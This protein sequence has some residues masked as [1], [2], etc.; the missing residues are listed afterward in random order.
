MPHPSL[1]KG[2]I[3][4]LLS[5]LSLFAS[6]QTVS[7][8]PGRGF[9]SDSISVTLSTDLPGGQIYFTTDGSKPTDTSNLYVDPLDIY[10]T[11]PLR[12]IAISASSSTARVTHT[13]IYLDSVINQPDSIAGWPLNTYDLGK[14]SNTAVQDYEMDSSIV[15]DPAYTADLLTGL[16]AIPTMSIVMDKDEF[17]DMNDG[18]DKKPTSVEIIYPSE[19]SKNEQFECGIES[20]SHLRTKRSYKLNDL[21]GPI[22]TN[23]FKNG[24]W[25]NESAADEFSDTKIVLRAGNNDA[26]SRNWLQNS[27]YT[28]DMWYRQSQLDMHGYGGRGVFVHL[29]VNGIYWGLFNPTERPDGGFKDA[30]FGGDFADWLSFEHDG[31]RSGDDT[32]HNYLKGDLIDKDMSDSAN[33]EELKE[34]LDVAQFSDYMILSW[35]PGMGDWPDN[36][37]YG[38]NLNNPPE[39][40]FFLCWDGE[41]TWTSQNNSS[42]GA[43]VSPTFRSS[44]AGGPYIADIWQAARQN[45]DFMQLFADRVYKHCFNDGVMTDSASRARWQRINDHIE[46]AIIAESARW[47]DLVGTTRTK[48]THWTPEVSRIDGLMQGNVARFL[49]ALRAE[50]YYPNLDAPTFNGKSGSVLPGFVLKLIN[51]NATGNI[52]YTLDGS[53]PRLP[54]GGISASAM[55]YADSLI[56][57]TDHH[58]IARVYDGTE[59]SAR[60]LGDFN[61]IRIFINEFLAGND[62]NL[63]DPADTSYDDWIEI[64][65]AGSSPV[66]VG[67]MFITDDL[68]DPGQYQIPTGFPQSTTIA[69]NGFLL[70]WADKQS[71]QGPLHV[72]IKL[73]K[74]GESIG[75]STIIGS[76]TVYLDSLSFGA[77]TDDTSYG[78]FPDGSSILR[79][80]NNPTP[81]GPNLIPANRGVVINEFL[82]GN[83]A[84]IQDDFGEHEDWI[85]LYNTTEDTIN[86]AGLFVTDD[87]T[88]TSA[89]WQIPTDNL[90]ATAIPP[91][92][93]LVLWADKEPEQGT[94][95]VNIKL[96]KSGEQIGLIQIV[97]ADTVFLDSLTFGPQTD[98]ISQGRFPDGDSVQRFFA[99]PTPGAPNL[100]P[101]VAGL[102]INEYLIDNVG[103]STDEH[104]NFDPWMEIFNA[105]SDTVDMAGL[106]VTNDLDSLG[107]YQIPSG[108][109]ATIIPPGGFAL[110]WLD[111]D[112]T[113]GALHL[114]ITPGPNAQLGLTNIIGTD[115]KILDSLS[116]AAQATDTAEGR[117]PDGSNKS[118]VF[119]SP[120]PNAPN[121]LP[122]INGLFINEFLASND[123]SNTDENGEF[124]DWIEIFNAN[125]FPVDIAGMFIT[126]NLSNPTAAQIPG[127]DPAATTIPAFG[128]HL[129]WAD[130]Q[131]SQGPNHISPKLSNG[132]EQIGL[133]QINGD[134]IHYIDTLTYQ[135]RTT[136]ISHG[137]LPDG[138]PGFQDLAEI[139]PAA[140]NLTLPTVFSITL[141]DAEDDVDLMDLEDG[142]VINIS[143]LANPELSLRANTLPLTV[144]SVEFFVNGSFYSDEG[145]APY[146]IEGDDKQGDYDP[147]PY[148]LGPVTITAVPYTGNNGSGDSGI[149]KSISFTIIDVGI[150][151][152][153]DTGGTASFDLCG[154]CTGGST[155]LTPNAS[156]SDC[157]GDVNGTA[158]MDSCGVCAGGNTTLIPNASCTDCAGTINGTASIDACGICAGGTTGITPDSACTDC[159][160]DVNGTAVIDSCGD[161]VLGNTGL[162]FNGGCNIDCAGVVDGSAQLDSCGICAG[163]T[164]GVTPDSSCRDC[165]GIIN[166]TAFTDSCGVC[167]GGSTGIAPNACVDCFGVAFGTAAVD[168]CGICAGGTSGIVPDETCA[169]CDSNEVVSL[170]LMHEGSGGPI[171]LLED[172]GF[173]I[174]SID[175]DIS[176]RADICDDLTVGSVVFNLDG[177]DIRTENKEPYS[178][179]GDKNGDYTEWDPSVGVHTLIVTPYTSS[180]AGGTAGIAKT[181]TFTVMDNPPPVDCHGDTGGTASMDLCGVCSGGNTGLTPNASCTDCNGEVNGSAAFDSCG[182]CAGGSTGIIANA[183][184]T[185]C[186]GVVNGTAQLD[187]CNICAGGN[188]GITPD[189]TCSD[190]NG[191][192][193]GTAVI[194]SCGDCVL[195][196]TGLTFNGGCF[197]DCAGVIDG[198]A[199]IDS[200]GICAGGTTGLVPDAS[201]SDCHGVANGT[202]VIDSCG[203]CVLGN[204]GLA[205][206]GGCNID[207][208]GVVDGSAFLDS[209]GV[210]AGGTTGVTPD[211][212]CRD[213]AGIINGNA[214]TDSCGICAGGTTGITPNACVDCN[215]VAYGTAEI[216]TCG[217]CAG[218]NTGITPDACLDCAGEIN[219]TAFTDSCGVCAGGTTGIAPNACVD[220]NGVAYGTAEVDTCG[221]CA[222]GNTGITP[223]A[224]LDCAG[225]VDGTAF[226]DN[227]G[228]CAG[229]TTGITPNAC[230]DCDGVAYGTAAIDTCGI[231]A[232]GSTGIIPNETCAGCD[233]NEVVSF[234]LM[235]AG[236]AGPIRKLVNGDIIIKSNVGPFSVRANTCGDFEVGSV[237]FNFNGVDIETQNGAPYAV[238]GDNNGDYDPWNPPAGIHTLVATPHSKRNG[239]GT[240]GIPETIVF[241]VL[242]SAPPVDC[243]GDSAGT[244]SMDQCGI[245]SGGNT[246][247][248]PNATCTDCNGE[249]NGTAAYDT[250]G[251]C[252]GGST[253]LV[254]N[255]SCTD[256]AGVLFG[257]AMLDAC[258]VC[259][260]GTTGNIPDESCTDCNG[261]VNGTAVID[262]CGDCVLGNT[263]LAFNGGCDIDC[264]GVVDGSAT[265]DSCGICAGGTTGITPDA[266]CTDCNGEI[267]GTAFTDSCGVCA[268][269]TTGITPNACVDCDGVPYGTAAVD[270]CGVCAGGSTGIVPDMSCVVSCVPNEVVSLMLVD[271]GSDSDLGVM[272]NGDT[273]DIAILPLFSVRADVC[274][275]PDV[276]SVVFTLDGTDIETQNGAPYAVNGDNNGDYTPWPLSPGSY[277]LVATPYS[278]NKG[279]GN[280][281]VAEQVSFYVIDGAAPQDCNGDPGGTAYL[282]D[283]NNCVGGNTGISPCTPPAGC[284]EFIETNGLVVVEVESVPKPNNDWYEGTGDV[285]DLGVP[286]PSGS[287]YMWKENCVSG[288]S[289]NYNYSGC[290]GTENADNSDA[291]TYLINFSTPGRY[292]FQMRSWQPDISY[293]SGPANSDNNDLWIQLPEGT[294]IKKD[295]SS[296][297]NIGSSEWIK[298]YQ[299][300]TNGWTWITN[301][302]SGNAHEIYLDVAAA[303]TYTIKLVG[304]SKLFV[305]DRFVFYRSDNNSN[306]VSEV[307][308]TT[309]MPGESQR[310]SCGG[311]K[312]VQ[313]S[314][315]S[316]DGG[317]GSTQ[318]NVAEGNSLELNTQSLSSFDLLAYPIPTTGIL[319]LD[320]QPADTD[321][322]IEL[323]DATGKL[324]L[325]QSQNGEE[326]TID[327]SRLANGMYWLK[328]YS[329]GAVKMQK[330]YKE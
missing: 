249:V 244:A 107:M 9:Y 23:L 239:K 299:N 43:W 77:Q 237:V 280:A 255:A 276:Q 124:D 319:H 186:A 260:G 4:L 90:A 68:T 201:R 217:V 208:A 318:G 235:H 13:Y 243:N 116:Y 187:A 102:V 300:N 119:S 21:L 203:D 38:G 140:S 314:G 132:G 267:N 115:I 160:G 170:T 234:T 228:I 181:V 297:I 200:C 110:F 310:G 53:D 3:T 32:R 147:W 109:P 330:V 259:A 14:G 303:G 179:N 11:T 168:T 122:Y 204:T 2:R 65:N 206:N 87:L 289:P 222:G 156:C 221:V 61:P 251:V 232:G 273:I 5:I 99:V 164:T 282:D 291:I 123:A 85:E 36:N 272:S 101:F 16:Q 54:G 288:S 84:N 71:E 241:T 174:K 108:D 166:G 223:D 326:N 189:S 91:L 37:F 290:S 294:G 169:A 137:R 155:G 192:P 20:H 22:S 328:V 133:I 97:G 19:P 129:I 229:G 1:G 180:N 128:F 46:D 34:Y 193:N 47:G 62:Q 93:Y 195:G 39:P 158:F 274:S 325:E 301:T 278:A 315:Q 145:K 154:V 184:C 248:V 263:G 50:G 271:A 311:A 176:L 141:I 139:T 57:N 214:Y 6:A 12:A 196:N 95:H 238:A 45:D 49:A 313:G 304:R 293:G 322:R 264:A 138:A 15:Y 7:L 205:F 254:P 218:G 41:W 247:L 146:A 165:A 17:W 284:G 277:T 125:P 279:K 113:Q 213:C 159:N 285:N 252:T 82:A 96:G 162:L 73:G 58:I 270:T 287:Y 48:N 250:C 134:S 28:R 150:D 327:L 323:Y 55:L 40:T 183:S 324:I 80:F 209:C 256:C 298:V 117:Y 63:A 175:G 177:T 92:D 236:T 79:F 329:G 216:D 60:N 295:N 224:C 292:R 321:A 112:T 153:G 269:G 306:N 89:F 230:V 30:Y 225:E 211:S 320:I 171:R 258:G 308:A 105:G 226:T 316:I 126:D 78:R 148:S 182:I 142:D 202:A 44:S 64:Y 266:S 307:S 207:C 31:V 106:F 136:G 149:A 220:C 69:A 81:N 157:N 302:V 312:I 161:C 100:V 215:G 245:C 25:H 231:C 262:T 10:K 286:S 190:C 188:T 309:S 59:W 29:Y 212:S 114:G 151:C 18:E 35:M 261:V 135:G 74:G 24:P 42:N 173:I 75:I 56:V 131:P 120:T 118:F 167:A 127:G 305:V 26:W 88:D 219:G 191:V 144:G 233:S 76:D 70:L 27:T 121:V 246:G 172:G 72:E 210:C 268:G 33:Y 130:G 67:G 111:G 199:I 66:D 83:D 227:C 265:I 197:I 52:Y 178:I 143:A 281:G 296:E 198:T 51:P 242:D 104:G 103:H 98:D 86:I 163:G 194:D 240:T 253:G 275:D 152:A 283:C 317:A 257:T 94:L 185:D 8:N